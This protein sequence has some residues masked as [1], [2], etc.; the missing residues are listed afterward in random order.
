MSLTADSWYTY[1]AFRFPE[2]SYQ[3][4]PLRRF[5]PYQPNTI[6]LTIHIKNQRFRGYQNRLNVFEN[7]SE[8]N[9]L[10]SSKLSLNKGLHLF[11]STF[12]AYCFVGQARFVWLACLDFLSYWPN[13]LWFCSIDFPLCKSNRL[14]S[15]EF[16][17]RLSWWTFF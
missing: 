14:L 17:G 10:L 4:H 6:H 9:F 8:K 1:D 5:A 11:Q 12:Q 13:L 2:L 7:S 15:P 16:R 3:L